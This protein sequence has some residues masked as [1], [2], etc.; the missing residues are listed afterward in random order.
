MATIEMDGEKKKIR[1]IDHHK[2]NKPITWI[3]LD[4]TPGNQSI[5]NV[6]YFIY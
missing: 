2:K 1:A 6:L 3:R 5:R 4:E